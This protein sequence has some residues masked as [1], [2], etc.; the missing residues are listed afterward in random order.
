MEMRRLSCYDAI[1]RDTKD[2]L[3]A[4]KSDL[5]ND[6]L[7]AIQKGFLW[8]ETKGYKRCPWSNDDLCEYDDMTNAGVKCLNTKI[9]YKTDSVYILGW[10]IS[11]VYVIP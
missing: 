10:N 1:S 6:D 8:S 4:M 5:K 3:G 9:I 11:A 7:G 2:V